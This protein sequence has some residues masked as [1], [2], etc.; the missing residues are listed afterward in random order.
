MRFLNL[1]T[2]AKYW[3]F[4]PREATRNKVDLPSKEHSSQRPKNF[5][6]NFCPTIKQIYL[7]LFIFGFLICRPKIYL[8]L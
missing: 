4:I 1:L 6:E 7:A 8:G 2:G 3:D 5:I